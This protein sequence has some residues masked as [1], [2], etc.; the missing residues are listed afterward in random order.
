MG[1]ALRARPIISFIIM[2]VW[3][4]Y[5]TDGS[6]AIDNAEL[7]VILTSSLLVYLSVNK[8]GILKPTQ[9]M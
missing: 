5:D 2:K 7:K 6:G 3:K 4:Q 1:R 9:I 8:T